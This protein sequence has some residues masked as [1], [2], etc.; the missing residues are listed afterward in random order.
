[1]PTLSPHTQA[2]MGAVSPFYRWEN[3]GTF[4]TQENMQRKW[5]SWAVN[6]E[7]LDLGL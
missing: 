3:R 5:W 1:M 7:L 6:P 4:L 2:L